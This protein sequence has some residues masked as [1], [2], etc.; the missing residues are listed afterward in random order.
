MQRKGIAASLVP[1]GRRVGRNCAPDRSGRGAVRF[2]ACACAAGP[3][4]AGVRCRFNPGGRPEFPRGKTRRGGNKSAAP[5]KRNMFAWRR[6]PIPRVMQCPRQGI[7]LARRKKVQRRPRRGLRG[8]SWTETWRA[9]RTYLVAGGGVVLQS[10]PPS[11]TSP[12]RPMRRGRL[13]G[14][15]RAGLRELPIP[16]RSGGRYGSRGRTD[17]SDRVGCGGLEGAD[18]RSLPGDQVRT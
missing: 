4:S 17:G 18:V 14:R 6:R 12:H 1:L 15:L 5:R 2:H 8:R 16:G 10:S 13:A 9:L 11:V 3:A 7:G